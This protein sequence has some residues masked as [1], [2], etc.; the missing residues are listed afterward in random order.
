MDI[1]TTQLTRVVPVPIKPVS[2]KVKA[3]LKESANAKLT[4]DPDHL[5]NHEYYFTNE[6]DQ[7]HT[8]QHQEHEKKRGAK[9]NEDYSSA[10]QEK[11][12]SLSETAVDHNVEKNKKIKHLDLYI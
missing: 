5:E 7:Y 3:L 4:Q 1:F 11:Q 2:L 12:S 8:S 10:V 9:N 6:E